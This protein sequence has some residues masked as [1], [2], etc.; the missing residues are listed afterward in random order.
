MKTRLF[1]TVVLLTALG[2]FAAASN[3]LQTPKLPDWAILDMSVPLDERIGGKGVVDA[4]FF[5]EHWEVK[6]GAK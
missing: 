6:A 4:N 2:S 3:S 5:G 1:T